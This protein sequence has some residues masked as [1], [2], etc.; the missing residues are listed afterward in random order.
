[1]A[2]IR[3]AAPGEIPEEHRLPDSDNILRIHGVRPVIGR[4]HYDLYRDLMLH[5]GPIPRVQREMIAVVVSAA[6]GCRYCLL[7]HGANLRQQLT[8]S[9]RHLDD[10]RDFVGTLSEDWTQA[11]LSPA[12]RTMLHFAVQLTRQPEGVREE[13]ITALRAVGFDDEAIHD[14]CTVAAYFNFVNRMAIGLGVE[15]EER[16]R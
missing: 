12:E 9:G 13:D 5:P 11:D 16:F 8:N 7:H 4:R 3:Y 6:N 1:M 10:S 15:L 14:L 2:F